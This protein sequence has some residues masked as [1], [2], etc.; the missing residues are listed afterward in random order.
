MQEK[1]NAR[2][3]RRTK[4]SEKPG[5]QPNEVDPSKAFAPAYENLVYGVRYPTQVIAAGLANAPD[6][7]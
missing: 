5:V 1:K 4:H 6:L 7:G 2:P 3:T